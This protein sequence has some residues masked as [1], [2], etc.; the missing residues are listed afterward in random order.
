MPNWKDCKAYDILSTSKHKKMMV[1]LKPGTY[2]FE[3]PNGK[4]IPTYRFGALYFALGNFKPSK[5]DMI[6]GWSR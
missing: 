1:E 2:N 4:S 5:K 6:Y 3:E